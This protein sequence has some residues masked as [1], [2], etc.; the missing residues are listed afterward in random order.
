MIHT[1][2]KMVRDKQKMGNYVIIL[3]ATGPHHNGQPYDADQLI[4]TFV[5]ALKQNGHSIQHASLTYGARQMNV[6]DDQ[7][8]P[9]EEPITIQ[10]L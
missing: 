2:G 1:F 9:T 10:P 6:W 8:I 4:A 3:E 7:A 5:A